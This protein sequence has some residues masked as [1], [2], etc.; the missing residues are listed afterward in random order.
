MSKRKTKSSL[1]F[2]LNAILFI[3]QLR[4]MLL[5][6][7]VICV[8]FSAGFLY[9]ID[10]GVIPLL[11]D[12]MAQPPQSS[13]RARPSQPAARVYADGE[14]LRSEGNCVVRWAQ[15]QPKSFHLPEG[16]VRRLP[17]PVRNLH[18]GRHV[19]ADSAPGVSPEEQL[20]SL[21]YT[22][23][24]DYEGGWLVAETPIG[25]P[26]FIFSRCL[27]IIM[28]IQGLTLLINLGRNGKSIRRT[29][30]PL[31]ELTATT[32]A[33]TAKGGRLSPE[34]LKRLTGAL[35]SI[36]VSHLDARLPLSGISNELK[37]LAEAINEMLTRIDDAYRSQV[38]FVSDASHELRTPI[39]VIQGYADLLTRW[40]TEDPETMRESIAAIR[41][42]ATAMK[43]LVEQLLFL[44]RGDRDFINGE[45]KA[46]NVSALGED[47]RREIE[48]IDGA[49][50]FTG[51]ITP[52]VVV[53]GN[54]G[55]LK[56]LMRILIDNSIKYT[57]ANGQVILRVEVKEDKAAI[58]V[59]D[60]GTGIP[61]EAVAHIFDRFYR[62]D[63]SRTRN[64]GGAGLGLSIAK[65]IAQRHNGQIEV[66]SREGIGTRMTVLLPLQAGSG[67]VGG[68]NADGG[69]VGGGFGSGG[70]GGMILDETDTARRIPEPELVL[71]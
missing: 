57:P 51:E 22:L 49:H 20:M 27:A 3:R 39:A 37:P 56:Q 43:E 42:E 40:G 12:N 47:V 62:A 63:E 25:L 45:W 16:V 10:A 24:I 14:I 67:N 5:L 35:D 66:V 44:A 17:G 6:D 11:S 52:G 50:R 31:Q 59:Q 9:C 46:V 70:V 54:E 23:S 48:M 8:L 34:A 29:L 60:E 4:I 53:Q 58:V 18:Y 64:T 21:T 68:G 30:K 7:V 36:N 15:T 28:A 41:Q 26:V 38:Q 2:R 55:M 65:W 19:F 61:A 69:S 71:R 32:Q 13:G 33:L 1:S